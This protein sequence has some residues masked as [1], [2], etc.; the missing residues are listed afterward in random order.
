MTLTLPYIIIVCVCICREIANETSDDRARARSKAALLPL[1]I[2][3]EHKRLVLLSFPTHH[4]SE[5]L[6]LPVI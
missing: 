1:K 3:R 4:L 2:R 5:A 6:P